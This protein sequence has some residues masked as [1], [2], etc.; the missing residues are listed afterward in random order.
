MKAKARLLKQKE[1][2]GKNQDDQI[3]S[4]L[5]NTASLKTF[6]GKTHTS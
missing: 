2:E 4:Y 3:L 5:C 1:I 6:L